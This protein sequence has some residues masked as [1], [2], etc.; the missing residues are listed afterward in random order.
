MSSHLRVFLEGSTDEPFARRVVEAAGH[1]VHAVFTMGG[2]GGIDKRVARWCNPTNTHPMLVL[3]DL[4]PALGK[5]CPAALIRHL[6]G[7][8]PHSATTVFR[9]AE[10]ELEAWLLAD[11]VAVAKYFNLRVSAIPGAPDQ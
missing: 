3:R 4:D 1:A 6:A 8:G 10:R 2:H 5:G 11:R 9:I 7:Q